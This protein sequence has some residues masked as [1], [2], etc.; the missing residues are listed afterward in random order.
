MEANPVA[1]WNLIRAFGRG[2]VVLE[3]STADML[4]HISS[5]RAAIGYNVLLSYAM[6]RAAK[7]PNIG[8]VLPNDYTLVLSRIAFI[9]R[10]APHPLGRAEVDGL[11]AVTARAIAAQSYRPF[12]RA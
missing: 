7:D 3:P 8:V 9:N 12:R 6:N 2:G 4:N 11:S 10:Q 1:F 5:G